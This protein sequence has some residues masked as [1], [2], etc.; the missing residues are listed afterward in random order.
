MHALITKPVIILMKL[1]TGGIA[2]EEM[3][4]RG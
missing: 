2:D 4:I 3:K 1:D